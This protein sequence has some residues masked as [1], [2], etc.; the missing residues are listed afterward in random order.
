MLWI[1]DGLIVT[2]SRYAVPPLPPSTNNTILSPRR[3]IPSWLT[4]DDDDDDD[5]V[6][7]HVFGCRA[8]VLGTNCNKLLKLKINGGGREGSHFSFTTC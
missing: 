8:D 4:D 1:R 6:G 7:H 3:I 5:D 2:C